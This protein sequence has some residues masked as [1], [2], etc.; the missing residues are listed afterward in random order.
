MVNGLRAVR[1][2]RIFC[3]LNFFRKSLGTAYDKYNW[4]N[5][6]YKFSKRKV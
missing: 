5:E 4:Q 6:K 1:E 2:M 3:T